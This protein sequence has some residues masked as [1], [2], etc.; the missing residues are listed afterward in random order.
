MPPIHADEVDTAIC[1]LVRA[2]AEGLSQEDGKFGGAHLARG[3]AKFPMLG[4]SS[5]PDMP[6]YFYIV[7]WIEERHLG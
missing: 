7:R 6:S 2:R 1:G 4:P 3:A 5:P